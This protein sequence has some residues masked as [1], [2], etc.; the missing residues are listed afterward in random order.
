VRGTRRSSRKSPWNKS[1]SV[2]R[3]RTRRLSLIQRARAL[4]AGSTSLSVGGPFAFGE[5]CS[6]EDA[7]DHKRDENDHDQGCLGGRHDPVHAHLLCIEHDERQ[8]EASGNR[9]KAEPRDLGRGPLATARR[10]PWTLPGWRTIRH[11]LAQCRSFESTLGCCADGGA[12]VRLDRD[13]APSATRCS[14]DASDL[15]K[16]V[17]N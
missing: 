11:S 13:P 9:G 7:A 5:C 15:A 12:C 16:S 10:S 17:A 8:D 2:A 14:A 3:T 6:D 4:T 1:A